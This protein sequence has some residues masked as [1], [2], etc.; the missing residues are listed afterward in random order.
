MLKHLFL[1]I[2]MAWSLLAVAEYDNF[3]ADKG[4][5]GPQAEVSTITITVILSPSVE[6]TTRICDTERPA[7]GC[8]F[9]DDK[10]NEYIVIP[11]AKGWNDFYSLCIAGH[12]LYHALGANH[13]GGIGCPYPYISNDNVARSAPEKSHKEEPKKETKK[14]T[15]P[16]K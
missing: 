9:K 11:A 2:T 4:G 7:A 5:N 3:H 6:E 8:S 12:E 13:A 10:G 14:D 15:K 1:A 16:G